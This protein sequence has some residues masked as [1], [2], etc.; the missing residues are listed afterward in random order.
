MALPC[1]PGYCIPEYAPLIGL[2]TV[3]I[4]ESQQLIYGVVSHKGRLRESWQ[5]FLH[6][7]EE[8]LLRDPTSTRLDPAD[9]PPAP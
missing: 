7:A 3:P 9:T 6:L 5:Y 1:C 8:K 4:R 2:T